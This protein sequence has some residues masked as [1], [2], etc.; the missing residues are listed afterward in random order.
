MNFMQDMTKGSPLRLLL[1][2]SVPLLIGSIFQQFYTMADSI[3]VGK[4]V[5]ADAL[6]SIGACSS[7]IYLLFSL[8]LGLSAGI[9]IVVP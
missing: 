5:G 2:F 9:G 4:F 1:S 3:I 6:A 8:F 7:V